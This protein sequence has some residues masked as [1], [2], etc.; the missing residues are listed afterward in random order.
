MKTLY[1]LPLTGMSLRYL[2]QETDTIYEIPFYATLHEPSNGEQSWQD[3]LK[4]AIGDD[5]EIKQSERKDLIEGETGTFK[6]KNVLEK[7]EKPIQTAL[8]KVKSPSLIYK[9]DTNKASWPF[10]Y[11]RFLV[12]FVVSY[13]RFMPTSVFFFLRNLIQPKIATAPAYTFAIQ[14]APEQ[15]V[16]AIEVMAKVLDELKDEVVATVY[17]PSYIQVL[18]K[19]GVDYDLALSVGLCFKPFTSRYL[20]TVSTYKPVDDCLTFTETL[21][22]RNDHAVPYIISERKGYKVVQIAI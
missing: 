17:P 2:N 8:S 5:F 18:N 4:L 1:E 11:A 16:E 20:H 13:F 21:L 22:M 3:K 7:F 10:G 12:E 14:F 9:Y 6:T 15:E 19:N